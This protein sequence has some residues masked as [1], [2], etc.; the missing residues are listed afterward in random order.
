MFDYYNDK[1]S[2]ERLQRVYDI[3]PLRVKQYLDAEIDY[4]LT[5]IEPGDVVLELGCGFGRVLSKLVHKSGMVV[6]IDTSVASLRMA[7]DMLS[8]SSN[9]RLV[10]A[11]AIRL[12]FP[13]DV[14]DAV[15]CIQNGISAFHVDYKRLIGEAVRV[16][17]PGGVALFS[18]YS[19][20]FWDDRL[21]W[22]R[23]QSEAGLLGELDEEKTGNGV[24]VCKDGFTGTIV[25]AEEFLSLLSGFDVDF[26]IEEIDQS[27][28]FC[29]IKVN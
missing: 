21:D 7:E 20:R 15:V 19:D 24:I 5:K 13:D 2:A 12:S 8:A 6:G 29:E 17:K 28:I 11:N 18:S 3:A 9:C 4:V 26:R 10:C 25:R 23:A 1:L 16:T 22:F 27:S 14:F